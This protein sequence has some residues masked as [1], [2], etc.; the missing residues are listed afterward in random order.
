MAELKKNKRA[1]DS[2][3][4]IYKSLRKLL[5]TKPLIDISITDIERE[6]HVSRSTFYRNFN[7]VT[8]VLEALNKCDGI[9][10]ISKPCIEIWF[11][12]HYKKAP[13][14]E[15]AS[16]ACIK[17]LC[18]IAGW[19]QYKKAVLTIKQQDSLWDNRMTAVTNMQNKTFA[20]KTYSTIYQ[21]IN[22][23]EEEKKNS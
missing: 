12:S 23:L 13:E 21:F 18:S 6:S 2:Q 14:T 15:L 1:L 10:L 5:L 22:I 11:I 3:R 7:N 16:E 9:M 19:E 20:N 4:K 8:E 17:Q